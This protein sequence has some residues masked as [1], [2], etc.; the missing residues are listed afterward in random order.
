MIDL[1]GKRE[2]NQI[3]I[4]P[5][6]KHKAGSVTICNANPAVMMFPMG[7]TRPLFIVVP[8]FL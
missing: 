4:E 6:C 7:S 1:I 2:Y 3:I 8:I 5:N